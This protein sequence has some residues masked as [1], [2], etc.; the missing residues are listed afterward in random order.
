M[1]YIFIEVN[2]LGYTG[3][4]YEELETNQKTRIPKDLASDQLT[5]KDC[6]AVIQTMIAVVNDTKKQYPDEETPEGN[7]LVSLKFEIAYEDNHWDEESFFN[8]AV[9]YNSLAEAMLEYADVTASGDEGQRIIMPENDEYES[10]PAGTFAVLALALHNRKRID[11]Y[12]GFLRTNDLDSEEVQ[13]WHIAS[14]IEKYGWCEETVKLA[15]ARNISCCG[16]GGREQF[17]TFAEDGLRDYLADPDKRK[18]F[19]ENIRSEFLS[20]D[21]L[22][23]RMQDSSEKYFRTYIVSYV[24]HFDTLLTKEELKEMEAFLWQQ[25][26]TGK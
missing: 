4:D 19:L 16:Q 11:D 3:E 26:E 24:S 21:K 8:E 1:S 17:K 25:R 7:K 18:A 20:W 22:T 14:I 9:L 13:M 5:E 10:H 2:A 12:I 15:V 6:R 23:S